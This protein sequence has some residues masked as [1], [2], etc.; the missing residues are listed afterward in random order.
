ME[1][2][3]NYCGET[4]RTGGWKI[5]LPGIPD[6]R[7]CAR[8]CGSDRNPFA[9]L[10]IVQEDELKRKEFVHLRPSA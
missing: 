4:R 9:E 7:F 8:R 6:A 1:W 10:H 2:D 3:K 5:L